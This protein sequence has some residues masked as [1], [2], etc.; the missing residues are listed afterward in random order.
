M[1]VYYTFNTICNLIFQNIQKHKY[2]GH[3]G[4]YNI[5]IIIIKYSM[6]NNHDLFIRMIYNILEYYIPNLYIISTCI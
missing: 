5:Y 4:V 3:Q 6:T 1:K 2:L